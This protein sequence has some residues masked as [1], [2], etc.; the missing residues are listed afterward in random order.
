MHDMCLND[1][2][3]LNLRHETVCKVKLKDYDR[4]CPRQ[5][6]SAVPWHP[7]AEHGDGSMNSEA[8]TCI[9]GRSRCCFSSFSVSPCGYP[10]GTRLN[11]DPRSP[12]CL[13]ARH[14]IKAH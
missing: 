2:Y 4:P 8:M 1:V 11:D 9:G 3:V 14:L 12:S 13:S 6:H 10:H 7:E 5:G